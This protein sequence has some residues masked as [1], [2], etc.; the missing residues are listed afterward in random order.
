MWALSTALPVSRPTEVIG[1]A[2]PSFRVD[3]TRLLFF[4]LAGVA[5]IAALAE[6]ENISMHAR[7]RQKT[8]KS[9]LLT[10]DFGTFK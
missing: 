2:P 10:F 8:A 4:F 9:N 3:K 7:L 1:S 6:R 5:P